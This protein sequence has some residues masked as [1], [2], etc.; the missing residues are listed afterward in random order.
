MNQ[1]QLVL[2]IHRS[3]SE[4]KHESKYDMDGDWVTSVAQ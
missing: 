4:A 2:P 3:I 1:A